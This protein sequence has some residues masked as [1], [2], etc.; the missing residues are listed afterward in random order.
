MNA[1]AQITSIREIN[2]KEVWCEHSGLFSDLNDCGTRSDWYAYVFIGSIYTITP[3]AQDEM[4]L[5][6]IPEE[7]FS[8]KPESPLKVLTSQGLCLPK[9]AIGD[10]W[11]FFLRKEDGKS[12]VLDYYGNDSRPVASAGK[13][14]E[15]LRRLQTIGDFAILRG[16]VEIGGYSSNKEPVPNARVFARRQPDKVQFLATA[17][18]DGNYEFQPLPPGKYDITVDP[19]GS[20]Q[21]DDSGMDLKGGSCWDL[22]LTRTPHA[23]ISGHVQRSDGSPMSD[24]AV[25]LI[26]GD[27][28]RYSID[29]TDKNGRFSW[30]SESPGEYVVGI[31]LPGTPPWKYGGAAGKG[32]ELPPIDIFYGNA[33]DRTRAQV[34]KLG[35]D[36]KRDD[37]D[38]IIPVH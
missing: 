17:D 3:A 6:I 1:K 16:S 23:R 11:L 25:V 10:R 29:K 26:D 32:I 15:T 38:F 9:M 22:R 18:A 37:I 21:P 7:V 14:I 31:N 33:R 4:E 12:I 19:V 28:E 27:N 36:E 8:G 13:A 20:F 34:I 5:K 35:A 24:V 30:D 2:G